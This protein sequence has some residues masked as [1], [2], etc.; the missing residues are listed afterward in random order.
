MH[1]VQNIVPALIVTTDIDYI[2]VLIKTQHSK[3]T[4]FRLLSMSPSSGKKG[5]IYNHLGRLDEADKFSVL[6]PVMDKVQLE[7]RFNS[8]SELWS[9]YLG[10]EKAVG[11]CLPHHI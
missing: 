5:K 10:N 2:H 9:R 6:N 7:C 3:N 11:S 4:T 8:H 1:N